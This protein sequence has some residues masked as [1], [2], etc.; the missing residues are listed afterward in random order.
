MDNHNI[1]GEQRWGDNYEEN[2]FDWTAPPPNTPVYSPDSTT[3]SMDA[4]REIQP[5]P[6]GSKPLGETTA[7][8]GIL[9]L[10]IAILNTV[11]I[12]YILA[13][14]FKMITSELVPVSMGYLAYGAPFTA[15]I[16]TGLAMVAVSKNRGSRQG[17]TALTIGV[18]SL[19]VAAPLM[20]LMY[21]LTT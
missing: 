15:I 3:P 7:L 11:P 14:L 13:T 12:I 2:K 10:I 17:I 5:E 9:A 20:L 16:G 4:T 6:Q 21:T 18:L 8:F 19:L 1:R